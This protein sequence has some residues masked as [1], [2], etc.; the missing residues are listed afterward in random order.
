MSINFDK[1]FI[2]FA[3]EEKRTVV[4]GAEDIL[5][6]FSYDLIS[7]EEGILAYNYLD[8]K[9]QYISESF[10]S[11]EKLIDDIEE[12]LFQEEIE[13]RKVVVINEKLP[14]NIEDV[15]YRYHDFDG[16][17][18]AYNQYEEEYYF[19]GTENY[20]WTFGKVYDKNV[21]DKI[22]KFKKKE[23]NLYEDF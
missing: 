1:R 8:L 4:G 3:I 23:M 18:Y 5:G 9:D 2:V 14:K 17:E 13:N 10:L 6:Y 19:Y 20:R 11:F 15:L 7:P 22:K 16:V 21:L 12:R